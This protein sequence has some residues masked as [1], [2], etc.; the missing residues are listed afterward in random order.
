MR[1][2]LNAV[3]RG[4]PRVAL[5]AA[6]VL[7]LAT[8]VAGC[9]S[10]PGR[11]AAS[12]QITLTVSDF[13]EFGYRDL[14]R[15]YQRDH[16][17]I[18]VYEESSNYNVHHANLTKE[19]DAGRGAGDIVAVEEGY[20]VQFRDRTKDFVNLL[21]LGAGALADRWLP[22]KW[23]QSLSAD[24]AFQ[25]GLGTDIG[26]LGM[27]YRR[28]LFARAGLPADR[29]T[30][31]AL[32]PTW[33]DFIAV[34]RR[35]EAADVGAQWTDSASRTFTALMAQQ[36]IGYYDRAGH[37]AVADN[38]GLRLAWA[39]GLQLVAAG[40]SAKLKLGSTAWNA[41]LKTGGFATVICPAWQ[42]AQIKQAAPDTSGK[43]DVAAVP[44]GG[45]NWGGSFLTIPR[46]GRH[47]KEAYALAVWLTA[48][49]Q[50]LT[51]FK[52]SGNLPSTPSLYGDPAVRNYRNPFVNGAPVGQI[53]LSAASK[54]S[55]QYQGRYS[56]AVRELFED[57]LSQVEQA[58]DT[59]AG[60]WQAAVR[61]AEKLA[62][63]G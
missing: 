54:L 53:F 33:R 29:A 12:A 44:G 5:L 22:W 35:F 61:A 57:G 30:V 40:E 46:Q 63:A 7:A 25:I 18:R 37:L 59:P 17:N 38:P 20:I 16:P 14:L 52:G 34:G 60:A 26:G 11:S 13:G 28:D 62:G 19:L 24:G 50:Q 15:D 47:I 49:R 43:W 58:N 2:V 6:L 39:T 8:A 48:P 21:D 31:S 51:I 1:V 55:P 4:R 41:A 36:K 3:R 23:K 27:C 10:M 32:W 9:G 45:G 42:I 56:V